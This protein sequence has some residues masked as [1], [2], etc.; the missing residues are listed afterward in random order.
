MYALGTCLVLGTMALVEK[1]RK[2]VDLAILANRAHLCIDLDGDGVVMPSEWE[3][4]YSL[5]GKVCNVDI[6]NSD[7]YR[8][9]LGNCNK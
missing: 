6:L 8:I 4:A 9:I 1:G 5:V 2:D 7:D 3:R